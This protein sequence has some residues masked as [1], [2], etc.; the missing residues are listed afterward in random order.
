[1][2][3]LLIV[4]VGVWTVLGRMTMP[5]MANPPIPVAVDANA[6]AAQVQSLDAEEMPC[7][8]AK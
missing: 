1:M 4:V 7:C 3:S 5:A 2:T 8:V 6:A